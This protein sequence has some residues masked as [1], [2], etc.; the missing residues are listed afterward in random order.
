LPL[1]LGGLR[2]HERS[3]DPASTPLLTNPDAQL[4]DIRRNVAVPGILIPEQTQPHR[5]DR[6]FFRVDRNDA[7]IAYAR[8]PR[9]VVRQVRR[10]AKLIEGHMTV[11]QPVRSCQQHQLK[12]RSILRVSI[13]EGV[14]L[15][16]HESIVPAPST[17]FP[18]GLSSAMSVRLSPTQGVPIAEPL[19]VSQAGRHTRATKILSSVTGGSLYGDRVLI[20]LEKKP[21]W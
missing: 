16:D 1:R 15:P 8:P 2:A 10:S 18:N 9:E 19:A 7:H 3:P 4:R 17:H 12:E 20:D 14:V 21:R 11:W 5:A 6:P 13:T